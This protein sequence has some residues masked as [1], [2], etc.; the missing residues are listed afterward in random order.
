[1]LGAVSSV[2]FFL[3]ARR[4]GRLALVVLAA[5]ATGFAANAQLAV[6]VTKGLVRPVPIAVVPFGWSAGGPP[7]YDI[8]GVVAADL[9]SSGRFAPLAV[10]DM[11]SRPTQPDKVN[12]T[13]WRLLK[14][15]YLVIGTL[16]ETAPDQFTTVFQLFDVLK[17]EQ[18]VGYRFMSGRMDL[19]PAAHKISDMIFEKLVG[20]PGVFS[21]QIAYVSEEKGAD[22]KPRFR[23]IVSDADGENAK[24]IANSPQPLLSPSWS[25]DGRQL[26]YA[27]FEGDQ[28]AVFVQTLR[29]GTRERVSA[30]RGVNSSPAF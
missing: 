25:P 21:T 2:I 14:V 7:A 15:D 29:A 24:I 16:T 22:G 18:I 12:F 3:A 17:G 30:R 10:S 26:A 28:E 19:R 8:A 20:V 1:M 9:K 13:D 11:V 23:L 6:T 5:T 27:S 4:Y